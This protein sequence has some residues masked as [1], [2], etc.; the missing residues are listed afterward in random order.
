MK[1]A[2]TEGA[3]AEYEAGKYL[4]SAG[5]KIVERNVNYPKIGELDIV[6]LDGKTLVIVEVKYRTDKNYGSPIEAVTEPKM[7]KLVRAAERY[8]AECPVRYETVRFDVCS[9]TDRGVELIKNA[10]YGRWR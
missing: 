1:N 5:Y 9:V 2:L 4:E 8:I 10:F 6:A 7:R 3:L